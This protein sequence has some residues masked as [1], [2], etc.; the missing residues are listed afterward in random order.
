MLVKTTQFILLTVLTTLLLRSA[1]SAQSA[2]QVTRDGAQSLVVKDV[3]TDRWVI[4]WDPADGAAT[5]IVLDRSGGPTQFVD[6]MQRAASPSMVTLACF[7]ASSCAL[8]PCGGAQWQFIDDIALERSFLLPPG[9]PLPNATPPS[10]ADVSGTWRLALTGSCLGRFQPEARLAQTGC[11][12]DGLV[13]GSV[14]GSVIT[15]SV[16]LNAAPRNRPPCQLVATGVAVT[17]GESI[18]GT[19]EGS[20]CGTAVE[21]ALIAA[22]KPS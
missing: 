10:C 12:I 5:G 3:G 21:G 6:C 18:A 15:F 20:C 9:E 13:T 16:D 1:A 17:D 11:G 4:T 2:V 14:S 7:G 22:R 8:A 19:Y